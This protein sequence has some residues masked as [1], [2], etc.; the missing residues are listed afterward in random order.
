MLIS[1][2]RCSAG[3]SIRLHRFW[4][5]AAFAPV[6]AQRL[7]DRR[8]DLLPYGH[9][10]LTTTA[11]SAIAVT[12]GGVSAA[13]MLC[14]P[15]SGPAVRPQ[16][17]AAHASTPGSSQFDARRRPGRRWRR[18][19]QFSLLFIDTLVLTCIGTGGQSYF[20]YADRLN[21]LPLGVIG[22]ASVPSCSRTSH[23]IRS[24]RASRRPQ[25]MTTRTGGHAS[26][27]CSARSRAT[28]ALAFAECHRSLDFPSRPVRRRGRALTAL[29]RSS[30][31]AL[32]LPAYVLVKVLTPGFYARHDT[33]T[34]VKVR[35]W[36]SVGSTSSSTSLLIPPF[37]TRRPGVGACITRGSIA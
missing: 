6:L 18:A 23:R 29:R 27:R 2:S 37:G 34:P 8:P 14:P 10:P 28:V 4:V 15:A 9:E 19:V 24:A 12:I 22:A 26:W 33:A 16:A 7:R 17:P 13:R 5:A 32:G 21:Q 35:I 25:A 3:S 11:V 36:C 20:N 31:F 1:L 30:L